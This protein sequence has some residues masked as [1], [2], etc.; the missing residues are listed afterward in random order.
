MK[1]QSTIPNHVEV[2]QRVKLHVGSRGECLISLKVMNQTNKAE[3][4]VEFMIDT[5]FNG[6]IQLN[7]TTVE[8]LE[9]EIV[10]KSKSKD[11][12][13][14]EREI[15]L[16]K[17]AIKL[18]DT[19][20]SGFPIQI[21]PRGQCL[22]GTGFLKMA[23]LAIVIDIASSPPFLGFTGNKKVRKHLRKAFNYS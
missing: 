19:I 16:T 20:I 13:G 7:Q 18:L 22:I 21:T 1:V 4:E 11:F 8:R 9:L 2:G 15:G 23:G 14:D 17:T 3:E 5:G 6:F 12:M 10:D